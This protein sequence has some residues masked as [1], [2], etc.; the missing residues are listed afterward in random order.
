ASPCK[1]F[2]ENG[3]KR[4]LIA[5]QTALKT[6]NL[7]E[8]TADGSTGQSTHD[9]ILAFRKSKNLVPSAALDDATLAALG[10]AAPSDDPTPMP[11]APTV[12][13]RGNPS[14]SRKGKPEEEKAF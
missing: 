1:D 11:A 6:Q 14:S 4:L 3:R 12:A 5:A 10:I 7:Y 8:G 13:R 9:A 2:S